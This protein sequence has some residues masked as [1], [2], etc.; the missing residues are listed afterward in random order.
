MLDFF[1]RTR[2]HNVVN[3][4]V[5]KQKKKRKRNSVCIQMPALGI[6]I[7]I[8]AFGLPVLTSAQLCFFS[9]LQLLHGFSFIDVRKVMFINYTT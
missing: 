2:T 6:K 1:E 9:S 3:S 7:T 5:E 4:L 8:L